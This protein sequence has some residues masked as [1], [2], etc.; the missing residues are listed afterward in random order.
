M[1]QLPAACCIIL[2]E[3]SVYNTSRM[4]TAHFAHEQNFLKEKSKLQR[5]QCT[6]CVCTVQLSNRDS[7]RLPLVL[8]CETT[9]ILAFS[10][11][12]SCSSWTSSW[13]FWSSWSSFPSFLQLPYRERSLVAE[14]QAPKDKL[15]FNAGFM[16]NKVMHMMFCFWHALKVGWVSHCTRLRAFSCWTVSVL[17]MT[18][19]LQLSSRAR[20]QKLVLF[21][22]SN[23]WIIFIISISSCAAVLLEISLSSSSPF[24]VVI[25]R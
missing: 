11:W 4:F 6:L 8:N 23:Y 2:A 1:D 5:T 21:E 20:W 14:K 15:T 17:L 18:R 22:S 7:Y 25:I 12:P 13:P 19:K 16:M 3:H 10:S 9:A 24:V